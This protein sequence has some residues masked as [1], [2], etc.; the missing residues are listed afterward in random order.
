MIQSKSE[1]LS[2]KAE[3]KKGDTGVQSLIQKKKLIAQGKGF[4]IT[5]HSLLT[6]KR[7]R[8]LGFI[9]FVFL[10][11]EECYVEAVL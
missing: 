3:R 1:T 6:N 10:G 9:T 11:N 8:S 4:A 5:I 7:G 2:R